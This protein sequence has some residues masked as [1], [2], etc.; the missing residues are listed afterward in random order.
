MPAFEP[1]VVVLATGASPLIPAIPGVKQ[2]N[3]TDA[4]RVLEGRAE[5]GSKVIVAGGGAVGC[6]V[7]V[8]LAE[9]GKEVAVVEMR[10][11]DFSAIDGLAP[12]MD[13]FIRRWLLFELWPNLQIEVI[14]KST[15]KEITDEGLVVEDREGRS[16]LIVGD[17]IVFAAGMTPNNDLK[18]KL[19]GNVPEIYEVGD[20]VKPRHIINAVEE[21]AQVGRII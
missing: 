15:F 17:T 13:P 19:H 21:A 20:C 10:D 12:D 9:S 3:V 5:I 4:V 11:T 1:D 16:R 18:E 6:E 8:F 2:D 14:G 7:A